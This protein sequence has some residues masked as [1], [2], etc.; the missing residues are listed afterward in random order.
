[1]PTHVRFLLATLLSIAPHLTAQAPAR[2][3]GHGF[4]RAADGTRVV[5]AEVLVASRLLPS[6]PEASPADELRVRSGKDGMFHA[7]LLPGRAYSAWAV[8][9]DATGERRSH[10]GEGLVPGPILAL[11]EAP[12][13]RLRRVRIT[14]T[15][16]WAD[17]GPLRLFA[18][19]SDS[20]LGRRELP[21]DAEF[22]AAVP[23]LPGDWTWLEVRSV[24]G[25]VL[26]M[27][28]PSLSSATAAAEAVLALSPPTPL[29]VRVVDDAAAPIAGVRVSYSFSRT[30]H[31]IETSLGTTGADGTVCGLVPSSN[32]L[33]KPATGAFTLVL[34]A[35]G[36]Q[37]TILFGDLGK[38]VDGTAEVVLRSGPDLI[39]RVLGK[40][41]VQ[42]PGLVLLPDCYAMGSDAETT[43]MGVPLETIPVDADGR[44]R[45]SG[46]HPKYDFRLL[47]VLDPAAARA[48]GMPL[49]DGIAV[50]PMLW[51]AVGLPPF[52]TPHDLG[53]LRL[54]R[55]TV[56]QVQVRAADGAPVPG[57][58]LSVTTESLY[59]SP[60]AYAC[61]RVGRLQFPLPEGMVRIG[62]YAP[63]F[64]IA[65]RVVT[66][67]AGDGDPA[68]DPLVLELSATRTV[69]GTVVDAERKPV[70]GVTVRQW[71]RPKI[72]DR[73]LQELAFQNRAGSA[74][75]GS[76]GAFEL[77][78][79]LADAPF[80]LRATR[81]AGDGILWSEVYGSSP[82]DEDPLRIVVTPWQPPK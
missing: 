71:D 75:T 55:M 3:R 60:L 6:C 32:P 40:D 7:D 72:N 34:V 73:A 12:R 37:R 77:V 39:G 54:D 67:P 31:G 8:W 43:G 47:A 49:R 51:L 46:L 41:G 79:P 65:T 35:P 24:D 23:T 78:L 61:D 53:E 58:R 62:A 59:H 69:R 38:L 9:S 56:A 14:D 19:A 57:A 18:S 10:V 76:D 36:R 80:D 44:F 17:R 16:A 50:A 25:M 48:A 22:T 11:D 26:T 52:G 21:L 28:L 1:M 33:Q 20:N 70:A 2:E 30:M 13:Q 15:A 45:F 66:V 27:H 81:Q 29:R 5:G 42:V 64:G 63:G 4:V 82:D 74:P 68:L